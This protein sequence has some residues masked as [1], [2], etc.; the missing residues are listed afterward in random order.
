MSQAG[1][2]RDMKRSVNAN[3]MA[4]TKEMLEITNTAPKS[5]RIVNAEWVRG[6]DVCNTNFF[7]LY[8]Q[9]VQRATFPFFIPIFRYWNLLK[10]EWK[11]NLS[12]IA[13]VLLCHHPHQLTSVTPTSHT[14]MIRRESI[15]V[16]HRSNSCFLM[17]LKGQPTFSDTSV[18]RINSFKLLLVVYLWEFEAI[19][20]FLHN[21]FY[22][23]IIEIW[24]VTSFLLSFNVKD[25]K[26]N[27]QLK[28]SKIR[29]REFKYENLCWMG[30]YYS[31]VKL[32]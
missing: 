25:G 17:A 10:W 23:F 3:N 18:L 20:P 5:S 7:E 9:R 6:R 8:R 29:Q 30:A 16:K 15:F 2:T 22:V 4:A 27:R 26:T 28:I 31:R 1:Q 14:S 11:L 12:T 21:V 19:K 24:P 13:T 32:T